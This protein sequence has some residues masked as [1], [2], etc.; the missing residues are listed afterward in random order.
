[1]ADKFPA[2]QPSPLHLTFCKFTSLGAYDSP[3]QCHLI[4]A[5]TK[6]A[7][8]W[9]FASCELGYAQLGTHH[10]G[11]ASVLSLYSQPACIPLNLPIV[12]LFS[13]PKKSLLHYFHNRLTILV[14]VNFLFSQ[15]TH[16]SLLILHYNLLVLSPLSLTNM[17]RI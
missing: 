10:T 6:Q 3:K 15:C 17:L 2:D 5:K 14:A 13:P 8:E 12:K 11:S 4:Y 9:E 7:R 1:L 16:N